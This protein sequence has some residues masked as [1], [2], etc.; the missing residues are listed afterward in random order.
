MSQDAPKTIGEL[1]THCSATH[2][3][4]N[5]QVAD[6]HAGLNGNGKPGLKTDV[7]VISLRLDSICAKVSELRK[8]QN[9]LMAITLVGMGVLVALNFI[10][11]ASIIK[12]LASL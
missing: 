1:A 7:A 5:R 3:T 6:I 9:R 10:P 11:G 4:L 8:N 2:A 12:L